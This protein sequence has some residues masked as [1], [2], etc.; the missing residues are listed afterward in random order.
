MGRQSLKARSERRAANIVEVRTEALEKMN[1]NL[2]T[3]FVKLERSVNDLRADNLRYYYQIGQICEEIRSNPDKYQG[4]DGTAGLKLVEMA[5]STQAR[6]LRK[7]AAFARDIDEEELEELISWYHTDTNFQLNWGHISF[8]LT[9]DSREKR[10][11]YAEIAIEEMLD[12]PALHARIKRQTG[13]AGGHGRT[14]Q[15][16]ATVAAQI[17]QMHKMAKDWMGKHTNI[18][19]GEQE[20]VFGNIMNITP[21]DVTDEM[22]ELLT[23]TESL[24]NE[25]SDAATEN[26]RKAARALEHLRGIVAARSETA[27]TTRAKRTR[28]ARALDLSRSA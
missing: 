19:N 23:E 24:L 11:Q 15:M 12:P 7:A 3:K 26:N 8:L 18:W 2:R 22:I 10:S 4:T 5:L 16:P 28:P 17:R 13:R 25:I 14:H 27:P 6:T 21:E 9:L 1:S 20:S